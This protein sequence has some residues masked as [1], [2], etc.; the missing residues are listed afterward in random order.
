MLQRANGR[1]VEL[2]SDPKLSPDRAR[3]VTADFCATRCVNE[4]AV[5]RVTREGIRK[6]Y[7]WKPGEAWQDA[8]ASWADADTVV[9]EY[10]VA[11]A[12]TPAKLERR[13]TDPGWIRP[14]GP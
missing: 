2:P 9:I 14:S 10:T 13:L 11:G 7:A 1:K 4:L 3:L 8:A 12:A 5:W 6:E